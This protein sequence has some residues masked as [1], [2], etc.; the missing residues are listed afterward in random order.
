[1]HRFK[2]DSIPKAF[3]E[4]IRK[5]K[6]KYLRKFSKNN[7]ILKLF[8]L[9]NMKFCISVRGLKLWHEFLQSAKRKSN[10]LTFSKN[11]KNKVS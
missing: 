1:M 7:S 8:S 2:N 4:L 10:L 5:P 6:H 11:C 3:T 9:S